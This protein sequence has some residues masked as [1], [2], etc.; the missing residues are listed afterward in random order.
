ME[1]S[2]A[3][4]AVN[5]ETAEPSWGSQGDGEA[6]PAPRR[7][8]ACFPGEWSFRDKD[9][10]SLATWCSKQLTM[11]TIIEYLHFNCPPEA[12]M[13]ALGRL[14]QSSPEGGCGSPGVRAKRW[15]AAPAVPHLGSDRRTGAQTQCPN[16]ESLPG[17]LQDCSSLGHSAVQQ[18]CF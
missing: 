8:S 9:P 17:A 3:L 11:N 1:K 4:L 5:C 16:W 7:L 13:Q 18:S 2:P 15:E 14:W 12:L 10:A 6:V